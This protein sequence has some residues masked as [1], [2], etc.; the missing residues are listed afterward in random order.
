M[1]VVG[2]LGRE[3][4]LSSPTIVRRQLNILGS[5][6]GTHAD[7]EACLHLISTGA[8]VP[9]VAEESMV[10]FP[11]VLEDLHC[12]KIKGRVVLIP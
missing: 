5:Y 7:V 9:Q 10:N 2:L 1:V 6:A 12:G 11:T 4:K 3:L 8:L